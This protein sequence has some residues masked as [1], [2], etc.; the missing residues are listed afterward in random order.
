MRAVTPEVRLEELGVL[1]LLSMLRM[2]Y[3]NPYS[4]SLFRNAAGHLHVATQDD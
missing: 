4:E 2:I 1:R 3:D